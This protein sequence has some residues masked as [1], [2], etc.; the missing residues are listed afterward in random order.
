MWQ[1][2]SNLVRVLVDVYG[3]APDHDHRGVRAGR[4]PA[5]DRVHPHR[6]C[7][8]AAQDPPGGHE[9]CRW[10]MNELY[11][12]VIFPIIDY[13]GLEELKHACSGFIQV[14]SHTEQR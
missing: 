8:P 2:S 3:G 13:Y 10:R 12:I 9:C 1:L 11:W 14:S 6:V 7:H 4:L 5:A